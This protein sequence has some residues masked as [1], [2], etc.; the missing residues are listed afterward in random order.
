MTSEI[1]QRE[2]YTG[3]RGG[4]GGGGG[5]QRGFTEGGS[6]REAQRGGLAGGTEQRTNNV[7]TNRN[8]ILKHFAWKS[9]DQHRRGGTEGKGQTLLR[10]GVCLK[11]RQGLGTLQQ[12]GHGKSNSEK[13]GCCHESV[14]RQS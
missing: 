10:I 5:L 9:D 11:H 4:E 7:A 6:Q 2:E 8:D 13:E 1:E 14:M 3:E 12:Q